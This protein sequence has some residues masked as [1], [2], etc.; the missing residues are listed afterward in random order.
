VKPIP[1][2]NNGP[3]NFSRVEAGEILF[4]ETDDGALISGRNSIV[5]GLPDADP[6]NIKGP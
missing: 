6:E 3:H 5:N 2:I 4:V 1:S